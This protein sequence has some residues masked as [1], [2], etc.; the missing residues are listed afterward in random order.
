MRPGSS[1]PIECSVQLAAGRGDIS[2]KEVVDQINPYIQAGATRVIL[3]YVAASDDVVGEMQNFIE[4]W[5]PATTGYLE[6]EDRMAFELINPAGLEP[7]VGYAHV[8]KITRRH[9]GSYGRASSFR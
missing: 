1:S 4:Y 7:P 5:S 2:A 3:P 9:D 8:A 6:I